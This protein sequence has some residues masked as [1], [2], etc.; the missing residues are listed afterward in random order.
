M[1]VSIWNVHRPSVPG[2]GANE[3]VPSG[4]WCESTAFRHFQS[5]RATNHQ[6]PHDATRAAKNA[7]HAVANE[8]S[9]ATE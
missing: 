1:F 3:C 9:A 7:M 5:R 8:L 2:L 6:S 4:K